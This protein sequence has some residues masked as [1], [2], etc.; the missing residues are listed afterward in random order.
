MLPVF[1]FRWKQVFVLSDLLRAPH[2][3]ARLPDKARREKGDAEAE[4]RAGALVTPLLRMVGG[5]DGG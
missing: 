2:A 3:V 5:S 4:A 1:V